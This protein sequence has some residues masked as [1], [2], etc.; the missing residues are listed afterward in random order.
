MHSMREQ[1]RRNQRGASVVEFALLA[2]I[3]V[4][5]LF[6][7]L[8]YGQYFYLSHSLQQIANNAARATIAGLTTDERTT[9]A[10]EAVTREAR[11]HGSLAAARLT[12][13]VADQ[14]GYTTVTVTYDASNIAL[15]RTGVFPTPGTTIER[16]ALI[17]NGGVS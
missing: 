12:S 5:L 17:R 7:M 11:A 10:S 6:G 15:L 3:F 4:T 8:G 2:P 14:N 9:I 1:L 16:R 13:S